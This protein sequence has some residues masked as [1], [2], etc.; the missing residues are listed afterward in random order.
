MLRVVAL[1]IE[2]VVRTIPTAP[3]VERDVYQVAAVRFGADLAWAAAEPRWQRYLRFPGDSDALHGPVRNAVLE[4]GIPARDGWTE[5]HSFLA[6]AD[7]VVAYN[8][9]ALDFPVITEA[10]DR[11]GAADP[12]TAVRTVDA[13]Y[14]AHS[15]WPF[16]PSHRLWDLARELRLPGRDIRSHT[17][18]GDTIMLIRLLERAA[19]KWADTP[20]EVTQLI[21][22][23]CPDSDAWR[24]LRELAGERMPEREPLVWEPAHV[25]RLMSDGLAGHPPRRSTDGTP[26]RRAPVVVPDDL[27][28]PD[29]RVDPTALAQVVHGSRVR[30]RPA[31]ERMTQALHDWTERGVSGLIEAPTGTGK[32]YAVLASA[33]DW[34][35][36]GADRTAVIATYTKQLQS[37]MAKDVQELERALPGVLGVSDLVKG[38]SNR[39]S[40]AALTKTLAEATRRSHSPKTIRGRARFSWDPLFRE[41][42]VF[43]MLRLLAAEEPSRSWTARSVDPVD[44]PAFFADYVGPGRGLSLWMQ[45]L[46]QND[47]DFGPGAGNPLAAHTDTARE[48][49]AGHRLILA[50]HAL[51]LSHLDDIRAVGPDILLVID[52]AHE[53][54]TAATSALTVAVDY[55]DVEAALS[56]HQAWIAEAHPGTARDQAVAAVAEL[57]RLLDDERLPRMAA[58]AFDAQAKGVGVRIGS[59]ATTLVSPYSGTSGT[60]DTRRLSRLLARIAKALVACRITVERYAAQ[61]VVRAD[62]LVEERLSAVAVHTDLLA[63]AL[64]RVTSDIDALLDSAATLDDALPSR[65]VH[66]AELAV[67]KTE[68]RSY[69]FRVASSPVDLPEDPEWRRYLQSFVRVH[70][71]SATLRVADRWDFMRSRLGLPEHLPALSLP[72]P[73]DVRNQARVVCFSDFPSWAEE[74]EGA[75]RTAAHQIAGFAAEM[76]R[77][78]P[79]GNGFDGGGMVLTTARSTAAG[80][81]FHLAG[82][83]RS[84]ALDTPVVEA[85][86][87]GNGRAYRE[88]T[89]HRDGGGFLVGTKGLWQGVD[90]SDPG[91]SRLVWINKLPF[92]SF[93]DPVVEARRAA[94]AERARR[95]GHPDPEGVA[96]EHYYLPLAALQLRQ[97]VGRLIRSD[98]HR[99]VVVISDRK[100]AGQS[101]LRRSYRRAFLGSLDAGLERPDAETGDVGAGNVMTM[102]QGWR[103]IWEFMADHELLDSARAAELCTDAAL[104]QHTLL[105]HTRRI[106]QLA[107]THEETRK[108]REE[109]RLAEEVV[110]RCA[111]VGGLLRL[112]DEPVSLKP[113]QRTAITAVAEGR[114]LLGLLPT[115]F[116]KS[117]TFQLPALVLPGVTVVVSPLV[118][119]MHDQALELNRSIG[120]AV[121]ALIS[122][123]RESS[124]RAGKTEVS[125]QL[126]GRADHRIRLVYVSPE[127]LC[128]RR[129][130]ETVR[131][132]AAAGRVTRIAVDEAHTLA[133]WE[134]FRPAM[135]RVSRFV[136]ELRRDHGVAV[137]AVTA[138]ANRSVHQALRTGLFALSAEVP[139]S[140]SAVAG[141]EAERPGVVGGLVTVRENPIRPEL[142]V[143]RRSLD[144]AGQGGV[145]G[146][147]ERVVSALEGHA[148]L[149]CLTVKEVNTLHTHLREYVGDAGIRVLRFHGRLTEAEKASVMTEFREAPREGDDGFAPVVIVATSAFGLGVNRPDVRTVMCVSPPTDLAAL[150]QQIGRAGRDSA[151]RNTADEGP[152]NSALALATSRGLRTVRFMTGQELPSALLRRMGALILAQRDGTLD[153]VRLAGVLMAEDAAT[154]AL[155]QA[156]LED[157]HT[158]DRYQGGVMRAFSALAELGAVEDLGDHPPY[159]V[160]KPGDLEGARPGT[161]HYG[162]SGSVTDEE[163]D[164]ARIERTVVATALAWDPSQS[165]DVRLLD[166]E[167]AH[168][169]PGYRS[170]AE[171][172][173][174]TWELLADLHDRGLMDVS[175]APSRRLVTGLAVRAG[176][177]PEG[178]LPLLGRRRHSAAEELARLKDF[179]DSTTVCAQRLFADYFGVAEIPDGSCATARCRCSSCWDSGCWPL[180]ERRPAVAEAFHSPRAREGGRTDTTLRD[181]RVDRQIHRLLQLQPQGAHPRRLWHALRGDESSYHPGSRR[182][183]SLPKVIRE[184]RH[185]GGRSDLTF[186]AVGESLTRLAARGA[187]VEDQKGLWHATRPVH[188]KDDTAAQREDGK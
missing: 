31:Q 183:I 29:G 120:G 56:E 9:T 6:D 53:L 23:V 111:L 39:L 84:R 154:G 139:D 73:F 81:G 12:L 57:D 26:S 172:P 33:L 137:T 175:A 178:Y 140:G 17:A 58:Q 13:L 64:D 60:R 71:V 89:D 20:T 155:S 138:T 186:P 43:L 63:T 93:A 83:L 44:L 127:R 105:P 132:A 5:L 42:A 169:C 149:Y 146:L 59:R 152:V 92:A 129:F 54:E 151:G 96:T 77:P 45:S 62:P 170:V 163:A 75:L 103:H 184:S 14:L 150:Y 78:R 159:C 34:L 41:L 50:N 143:F 90:V 51:V 49:I 121:R 179:F 16:A 116:G 115:G 87:L 110:N 80:I 91:R 158:Q 141:A 188:R 38:K 166:R 69:R 125:D 104:E 28:G 181:Q 164:I 157:G 102:A 76:T 113:A 167:L 162:A 173:A 142:A 22:D 8:G 165:V 133:Q 66:L 18:D 97:A 27:R 21:A 131:A 180:E 126:L 30:T 36:G 98:R 32:S 145:A 177:P 79:D 168:H 68:L 117:F 86:T 55:Q 118:A 95:A 48:A 52:E 2:S 85:L 135:R 37:Q 46:S 122:P 160:V 99:G 185:F 100:L 182:M 136:D 24:L 171:G 124:S 94:V 134:D 74:E 61:E 156:E 144:R 130:R 7:V 174:A 109:G 123:L 47:G 148:I 101:S 107:L 72:S 106:R 3:Y 176:A 67:P 128:Q 108:L 161:R 35:A 119:L 4:H 153:P 25:V 70:Y 187:V 19:S 11:A 114:N 82:E 1:D 10:A 15:I 40:L 147:V 88:F 112:S 65:V